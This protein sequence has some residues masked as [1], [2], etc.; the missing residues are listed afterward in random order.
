[1]KI[2]ALMCSHRKAKNTQHALDAFLDGF[3]DNHEVIKRNLIDMNIKMCIACENC[4]K[5]RGQCIH[6][7]DIKMLIEEML[8]SDLIIIASPLYFN[9]ATTIFKTM[10]DRTQVLYNAKYVIKDPIFKEK[11]NLIMICIG[12]STN[13]GNQFEGLNLDTEHFLKNINAN[14]IE[15]IKYNDTDHFP[16]MENL[17][18]INELRNKAKEV[19]SIII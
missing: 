10:I 5:H 18:F 12:G 17:Q 4:S 2:L 13:Y 11:K 8:E 16:V 6:K 15:C 3:K 7:D 14:I 19:E 9:G 1:M